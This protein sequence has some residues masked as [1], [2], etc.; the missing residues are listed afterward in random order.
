MSPAEG[1]DGAAKLLAAAARLGIAR[2]IGA[3]TLQGIATAAGVSKALVL[4][5]FGGKDPLLAALARQLTAISCAALQD[6]A[7]AGEPL[8]GWRALARD[9]GMRGSH[10]LLA[11]LLHE[12][13]VRP[14]ATELSTLREHAAA[15]LG[16]ALFRSLG[17][18]LK[19]PAP[20]LGRVLLRQLDGLA[21]SPVREASMLEAEL[22]ATAL[23]LLSL[24][25]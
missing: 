16:S 6:A 4:Y 12:E 13:E 2:G 20:L 18:T 23:A 14:L 1:R 21:S 11:S 25:D 17:L 10:A 3:L 24:A 5:H 19:V 15:E 22:D 9:A 7:R 8:E